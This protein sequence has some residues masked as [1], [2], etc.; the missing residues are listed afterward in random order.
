MD[1]FREEI[2]LMSAL[3]ARAL[4]LTL[5]PAAGMRI[6]VVNEYRTDE[7]GWVQLPDLAYGGR[8][9]RCC[10]SP[11]NARTFLPADRRASLSSRQISATP[12]SRACSARRRPCICSCRPPRPPRSQRS[13]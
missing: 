2:A 13:R 9:G 6:E 5:T 10:G 1:L 7:A 8:P 3:C 11:R 4:R 12:T